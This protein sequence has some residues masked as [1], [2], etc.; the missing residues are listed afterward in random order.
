MKVFIFLIGAFLIFNSSTFSQQKMKTKTNDTKVKVKGNDVVNNTLNVQ[1]DTVQATELV[2]L[3]KTWLDAMMQH[4]SSKLVSM[5][6]AEYKLKKGDGT[7]VAERAM[8]LTN[9]FHNLKISRFEQSAMNAQVY[10]NVGI[11]TSMYSWAGTMHN[12]PFDSK[13]YITDVWLKRNNSWQ[14]VSRTSAP[15]PG[16]NTLEGK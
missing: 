13:G 5:M 12:N 15:F 10:G 14:V 6:A 11:V 16:S 9:L 8:W 2:K 7:V 3:S 4:D 1:A